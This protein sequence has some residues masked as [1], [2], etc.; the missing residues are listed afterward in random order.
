M[1]GA[2]PTRCLVTG[3][4]GFIGSRLTHDLLRLHPDAHVTA[5]VLPDDL[6]RVRRFRARLSTDERRR[7][8]YVVGDITRPAMGLGSETCKALAESIQE[9]Y[10]LAAFYRLDVS[11][12][13]AWRVN[14]LGTR[15]VTDFALTCPKLQAFHHFSSLVADG[16]KSVNWE[17]PGSNP[18]RPF[19]NDYERSKYL[20]EVFVREHLSGRVPVL[21]IFRPG[22]VVGDQKTG[23]TAK[24]DGF[25]LG[26]LLIWRFR[27]LLRLLPISLSAPQ[28]NL[29]L[30]PVDYVSQ[31]TLAIAGRR[32]P[33]THVYPITQ[34]ERIPWQAVMDKAYRRLVGRAPL[35]RF[36]TRWMVSLF[37]L[38]YLRQLLGF[39]TATFSYVNYEIPVELAPTLQALAGTGVESPRIDDYLNRVLEFFVRNA[40]HRDHFVPPAEPGHSPQSQAANSA[41]FPFLEPLEDGLRRLAISA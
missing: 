7:F 40:R 18:H 41:V 37:R 21:N 9:I 20:S 28:V 32:L 2:P 6:Q 27:W 3:A 13:T 31:A 5:L 26:L 14:Y 11:A 36:R 8:E 15:S 34:T 25:Y 19:L 35:W 23:A 17:S 30:V 12:E 38:P 39:P 22:I 29:P 33:G 4:T 16:M 1:T 10:H 24:F